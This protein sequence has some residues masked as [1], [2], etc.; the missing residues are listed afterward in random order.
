MWFLLKKII[1]LLITGDNHAVPPSLSSCLWLHP[2]CCIFNRGFVMNKVELMDH[3]R[4]ATHE[5]LC[6]IWR[7]SSSRSPYVTDQE[8]FNLLSKRLF[9]E[10]GGFTPEISKRLGWDGPTILED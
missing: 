8:A 5:E 10:F 1:G 3:L 2:A 6:R 9:G 7:F 4:T